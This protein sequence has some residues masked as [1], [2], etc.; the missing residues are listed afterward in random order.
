[1]TDTANAVKL[2]PARLDYQQTF[3]V[4]GALPY[5]HRVER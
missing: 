5:I 1:M 3:E 2:K 4:T